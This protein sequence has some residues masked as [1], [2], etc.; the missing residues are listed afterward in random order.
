MQKRPMFADSKMNYLSWLRLSVVTALCIMLVTISFS[1][2]AIEPRA[3]VFAEL[4]T[5]PK[6]IF[7]LIVFLLSYVLVISEEKTQLRKSKPVMLGAGIIWLVIAYAAPQ[8]GVNKEQL[9]KA[10]NHGLDEYSSLLLFLLCAMTYISVLNKTNVFASMRS[11]L[12][13]LGLSY[14]QLFWVTGLITFFLSPI[15]DNLTTALVMG[16]V[17]L[18][19]GVKKPTF[20]SIT[21]VNIVCATNAGGAFSPFGDITTLMVWQSGQVE[22]SQFFTLFI[23]ALVTYLIPCLIMSFFVP[24]GVPMPMKEH[25]V[26]ARGGKRTIFLGLLSI[27]MAITFE[28]FL[29]LPPFMGMMMGMSLLMFLTYHL[30]R[31]RVDGEPKYD[32]FEDV[33]SAE[34]DTLLFFFG[35]MFS[36]GA[37]T[38]I[39]YMSL[40]S[41]YMYGTWGATQTNLVLGAI[42]AVIDN[43]PVMFSV[44]SMQPQMDVNQWLL[45]TLTCGVGGS[46]LSVGSAAGVALM[47]SAK[48]QY[49][50]MSHLRWTPVIALGYG[51]GIYTHLFLNG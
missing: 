24:S 41:D 6:G 10:I 11:W 26:M 46:L 42:S 27:T 25:T 36:V 16:S 12:V 29:G 18:A 43:I 28:Q 17:V 22:F 40:A 2:F 32:I 38:F 47:G 5:D 9:H 45:I 4:A 51:A 35:V 19:I 50:F 49:T 34:W 37:L 13:N 20:V 44:L 23:P 48:G 1:A 3:H 15:A 14:R 33:R 21:M 30:R 39:G 31:T 7:C 8:Y